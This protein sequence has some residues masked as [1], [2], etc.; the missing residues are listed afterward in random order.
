MDEIKELVQF[1]IED[2]TLKEEF[3]N[4]PTIDK[5]KLLNALSI[6]IDKREKAIFRKYKIKKN[7][8]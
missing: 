4:E 8:D 1:L 6:M 7:D 2:A 3:D 5:E